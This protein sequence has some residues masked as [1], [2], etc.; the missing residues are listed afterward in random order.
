MAGA[1]REWGHGGG[2]VEK[3]GIK[4]EGVNKE[5]GAWKVHHIVRKNGKDEI[6]DGIIVYKRQEVYKK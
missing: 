1:T 4:G 2:G 6:K 5:A 3:R